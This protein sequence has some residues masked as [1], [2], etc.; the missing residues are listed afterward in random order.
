MRTIKGPGLMLAQFLG[1]EPPF[2]RLD[3]LAAWT[4]DM[5]YEAVQLPTFNPR[6]FDLEKG[7]SSRTYCDDVKGLLSDHGIVLAE[8]STH[9]Q[10]HILASHP[11]YDASSDGMAP[12]EVRHDPK[13]RQ[14]WAAHQIM[15]AA[16]SARNLG[17]DRHATF[18]GSLLW[19]F[20]YPYPPRAG[21]LVEEAF[22]ELAA[23]WLPLLDAF[24]EGGVDVAF[25]IHPGE[26]LHDGVT[27][28]RFLDAVDQHPRANILYDPSHLYLQMMDYV[29]FIEVYAER[30]KCFH[31]KDA[32]LKRSPRT[33]I[34]GGYQ[35]W[36]QRAARFRSLG[37][38][39]IDFNAIF[40]AMTHIDYDGWAVVEWEC[41]YKHPEEGAREGAEFV[42]RHIIP[43]A[44][45]EFD[46]TMQTAADRDRNRR[47]LGLGG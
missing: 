28:E 4:A 20:I 6:V 8:L 3:T 39:D 9:R 35:G 11:A 25:E 1:P 16:A 27:F 7:A 46:A 14:E 22:A 15:L 12:P 13:A 29:G 31:V 38:G 44:D 26:D 37:D 24:D 30:I 47:I 34:W 45:R 43:V 21:G 41:C 36:Q 2:D 40:S 33:G 32:E 10:G 42:R 18:S 5:G 23:R 19:P 17:L